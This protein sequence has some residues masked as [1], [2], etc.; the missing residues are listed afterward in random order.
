MKDR[1]C[2]K[3][4]KG[5]SEPTLKPFFE[6]EVNLQGGNIL[7]SPEIDNIQEAIDKAALA[8]LKCSKDV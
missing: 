3:K 6:V 5:P 1:V 2:G 8:M 4:K 7:L